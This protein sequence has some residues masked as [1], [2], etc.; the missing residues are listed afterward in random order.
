MWLTVMKRL[1]VWKYT[2]EG[3]DKK[4]KSYENLEIITRRNESSCWNRKITTS[5]GTNCQ[6]DDHE[7]DPEQLSILVFKTDKG[8]NHQ[9]K[10]GGSR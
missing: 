10:N 2:S 3:K 1:Q 7:E 4:E 5:K 9:E 8:T 6:D